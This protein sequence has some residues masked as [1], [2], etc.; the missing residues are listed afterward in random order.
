MSRFVSKFLFV[1]VFIFLLGINNFG[2]S[3][4]QK[5]SEFSVFNFTGNGKPIVY[6][7]ENDE[8][9]NKIKAKGEIVDASVSGIYCGTIATGG[10][11]KIKLSEKVKNY[12]DDYLYLVV[13]CLAGK[14]NENLVGKNIEVEVK[15][16]TK[17]PYKFGVLMSNSIDSNGTPFY[18]STVGGV[19]GL[20]KQLETKT[21]K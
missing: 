5:K 2:Q 9:P 17:F 10:T 7:K 18:L 13:L 16:L 4:K 12:S 8:I 1:S 19:G 6:A 15:K 3:E 14:E 21:N 20:L 11:L